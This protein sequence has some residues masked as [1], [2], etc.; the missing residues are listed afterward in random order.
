[1]L[2]SGWL[3]LRPN[4]LECTKEAAQA[5][6][7]RRAR[8]WQFWREGEDAVIPPQYLQG[9]RLAVGGGPGTGF[10]SWQARLAAR[11]AS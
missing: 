9:H 3:P 5:G 7:Q 11:T 6:G 1:M 10:I 2:A 4:G 8:E